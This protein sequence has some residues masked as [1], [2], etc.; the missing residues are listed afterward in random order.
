MARNKGYASI[1]MQEGRICSHGKITSLATDF[2][3]AGNIPFSLFIIEKASADPVPVV[4]SCETYQ[5]DGFSDCPFTPNCWDV[6]AVIKIE[7]GSIDL[8]L[9]DVYWGSGL[10]VSEDD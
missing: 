3:L 7:A 5:G 4:V 9:Y 6:P 10:D 2:S 8:L 1:G